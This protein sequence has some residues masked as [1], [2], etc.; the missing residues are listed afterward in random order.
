MIDSS[1]IRFAGD[2][3]IEDA[4]IVTINGNAQNITNQ[5]LRIE[6]FEDLFS[7]F[8]TGIITVKDH[9][10][11]VNLLPF[12]GE[13]F[14]NLKLY[15]PSIEEKNH[16][17]QQFYIYKVTD[18]VL[19]GDRTVFYQLHIIS[20]EAI[21][22]VNKNLSRPHKGVISDI[23][24]NLMTNKE[25]G[26][27][28][29]KSVNVETTANKT[30]FISNYWSPVKCLNFAAA[31]AVTTTGS[32][33]FLFFENRKGLNF[34][35]LESLY[36]Q[37]VYQEFVYD[38]YA[39]DIESDGRSIVNVNQDYKRIIEFDVPVVN[40]Y[41]DRARSGMFSSK[42][43]THDIFSK[44]YTSKNFDMIQD[45]Q[46]MYHLNINAPASN[47]TIR[48]PN[49]FVVTLPK[50]YGA[51]NNYTDVTNT[52]SVQRRISQLFQAQ[53]TKINITVLGRTDYT[54]GMKVKV[55]TFKVQPI[56][57][58]DLNEDVLDQ[59]LSGF[60]IISAINHSINRERHEC[61]MELIKDSYIMD[62]NGAK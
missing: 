13:E 15:T 47:K 58:Q 16:I 23:A 5:I 7:P 49:S 37:P 29:K 41:L 34:V 33:N 4:T 36:S 62:L 18:R 43:N 3:S 51:F 8:I 27:E 55:E 61:S 57:K 1:K 28:T 42:L 39:R 40:N 9:F 24:K 48:Y 26:L 11:F 45:Y 56:A 30:K 19:S 25:Y 46:S 14:I 31:T 52:T 21:A 2:V 22:D 32:A 50:M 10:D 59:I 20:R 53:A 35:S 6:I 60:Y 12:V 54:V 44:K 17:N 38:N